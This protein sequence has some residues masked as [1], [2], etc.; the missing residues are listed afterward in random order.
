MANI[1]ASPTGGTLQPPRKSI[2]LEDPGAHDLGMSHDYM[3]H[4]LALHIFY[5][6]L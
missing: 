3:I 1:S 6:A 2:E 4:F 5:A